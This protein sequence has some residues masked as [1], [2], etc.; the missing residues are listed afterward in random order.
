[1]WFTKLDINKP[2]IYPLVDSDGFLEGYGYKVADAEEL[3]T[4]HTRYGTS[5]CKVLLFGYER[6]FHLL[7]LHERC[8]CVTT[9]SL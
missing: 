3:T 7:A 6:S 4:F 9:L 5:K 1:M 8:L 2:K